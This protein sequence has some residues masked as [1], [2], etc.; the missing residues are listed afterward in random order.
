MCFRK[1]A[2]INSVGMG[3]RDD[4]YLMPG[5]ADSRRWLFILKGKTLTLILAHGRDLPPPPP[6]F[7]DPPPAAGLDQFGRGSKFKKQKLILS[8]LHLQYLPGEYTTLTTLD[9]ASYPGYQLASSPTRF[10]A[11]PPFSISSPSFY[12]GTPTI[13][14]VAISF[15]FSLG[16]SFLAGSFLKTVSKHDSSACWSLRPSALGS[17]RYNSILPGIVDLLKNTIF[18]ELNYLPAFPTS[19]SF[20]WIN[21]GLLVQDVNWIPRNFGR[22]QPLC[23]LCRC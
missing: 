20:D 17:L 7:D 12:T 1:Q 14:Q 13:T 8:P 3:G 9:T 15:C 21:C 23:P 5:L 18:L 4:G 2:A 16:S 19:Y 22:L 10:Q 6:Q 11:D